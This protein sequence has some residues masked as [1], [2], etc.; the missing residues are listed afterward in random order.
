VRPAPG[1]APSRLV[2]H[3]LGTRLTVQPGQQTA[4]IGFAQPWGIES[5]KLEGLTDAELTEALA[6]TTIFARVTPEQKSRIIRAQRT[7]G[8]DVGFLGDG[9]N[10]AIALHDADVGISVDTATDVAKDAAD[11]VLLE[12]DLAS[13]PTG[14][15]RAGAPSRTRS[16]TC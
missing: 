13:S 16:S 4:E 5:K 15:S 14:W 7:L 8:V 1:P 2:D 9:V 3:A 10:D 6:H 11:V 12:K